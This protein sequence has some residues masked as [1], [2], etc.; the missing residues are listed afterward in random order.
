[1]LPKLELEFLDFGDQFPAPWIQRDIF[2]RFNITKLSPL[3]ASL[4]IC[5]LVGSLPPGIPH[6]PPKSSDRPSPTRNPDI[7]PSFHFQ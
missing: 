5:G 1:I 4:S 7:Q 2:P 3:P 6:P